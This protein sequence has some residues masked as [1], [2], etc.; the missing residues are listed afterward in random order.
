MR[1]PSSLPFPSRLCR[2]LPLLALALL[3]LS[4][5]AQTS[6][7][8]GTS[9]VALRTEADTLAAA[10]A[11][12]GDILGY[13]VSLS[14]ERALVGAAAGDG[15][16]AA[17]VFRQSASGWKEEAKL[18]PVDAAPGDYFG[19]A[20]DLSGDRALV[21]GY[22]HDGQRGAAYVFVRTASGWVQEAKL[23]TVGDPGDNL[24]VAVSLDG[25]RAVVGANKRDGSRGAAYVF[26]RTATGWEVEAELAAPD[27]GTGDNFGWSV[28]LNGDRVV[29][30]A[31]GRDGGKGAAYVFD[32]V[33]SAW[34]H[35]TTLRAPDAS[36]GDNFGV[37]VALNGNHVLAGAPFHQEA[38]AAYMFD[39]SGTT[40]VTTALTDPDGD[41]NDQFG[42]SVALDE[43]R[44][45]V[46]SRFEDHDTVRN[47]GAAFLYGRTPA[48]WAIE[49]KLRRTTTANA[50]AGTSVAISDDYALIG[51]PY[52]SRS[53]GTAHV[54]AL[55]STSVASEDDGALALGLA[56]AP[57]PVAHRARASFGLAEAGTVRASVVDLLGREVAV[58][59]DAPYAAGRHDLT[60]DAAP[61]AAGVYLLRVATERGVEALRFTVAR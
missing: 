26:V 20:V 30:G 18:V 60:L 22:H 59:A 7:N 15:S 13:A 51:A 41:A 35:R 34:T 23:P 33:A 47:G 37:S 58:L 8:G 36:A 2:A 6:A 14:G 50:G 46:G 48:G 11:T 9:N 44:A 53:R 3:T 27:A 38:G 56:V 54:F 21:G 4:A 1:L 12:E 16:G 5:S 25:D 10:D 45:L 29:V 28:A 19:V 24:G 39:I 52:H 42:W 57:N 31:Y 61:L 17:Y 32:R 49:S 40:P 55:A 43:S